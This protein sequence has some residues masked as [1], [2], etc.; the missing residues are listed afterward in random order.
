VNG[1]A[2]LH[3]NLWAVG[4]GCVILHSPDGGQNWLRN[5]VHLKEPALH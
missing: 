4:Y 1:A 2:I 5:P 3:P